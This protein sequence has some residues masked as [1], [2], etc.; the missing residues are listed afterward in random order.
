MKNLGE[1]AGIIGGAE[2]EN[3]VNSQAEELNW[4][5]TLESGNHTEEAISEKKE[6]FRFKDRGI[7]D[8]YSV[9]F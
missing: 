4:D 6:S 8:F 9:P 7:E 3:C 5:E 1:T 2:G